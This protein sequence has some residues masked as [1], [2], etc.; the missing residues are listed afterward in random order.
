MSNLT[1]GLFKALAHFHLGAHLVGQFY[2]QMKCLRLALPQNRQE[3]LAME[4][5]AVGASAVGLAAL[6]AA[7]DE[8]AGKHLAPRAQSA[9]QPAAQGEIG[10][11]GH[12]TLII[13]SELGE[14]KLLREFARMTGKLSRPLLLLVQCIGPASEVALRN[15]YFAALRLCGLCGRRPPLPAASRW[16]WTRRFVIIAIGHGL[17]RRKAIS[18]PGLPDNPKRQKL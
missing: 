16:L 6:A 9:N 3:K 1:G 4:L 14:V 11:V 18:G 17:K 5:L 15:R 2:G 8:R 7:F 12:L 10:V 13:V